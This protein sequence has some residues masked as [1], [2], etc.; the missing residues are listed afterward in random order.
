MVLPPPP[1]A[2]TPPPPVDGGA[3]PPPPPPDAGAPVALGPAQ[4]FVPL[5]TPVTFDRTVTAAQRRITV[6]PPAMPASTVGVV[7]SL[8]FET[9]STETLDL[10][11]EPAGSVMTVGP[12]QSHV[13]CFMV[14]LDAAGAFTI[15][16]PGTATGTLRFALT[17]A[18][19]PEA[20]GGQYVHLLDQP[21]RWLATSPN[22][23]GFREIWTRLSETLRY[24]IVGAAQG[25]TAMLGAVHVGPHVWRDERI[26]LNLGGA[27][28]ASVPV[29]GH[30]P[31]RYSSFFLAPASSSQQL[32]VTASW[33]SGIDDDGLEPWVDAVGYLSPSASLVYRPLPTARVATVQQDNNSPV[34]LSTGL[35]GVSGV[36]GTLTFDLPHW[37]YDERNR[38]F[39]VHVGADESTFPGALGGGL[40]GPDWMTAGLNQNGRVTVRFVSRVTPSGTFV[41]RHH[42][43]VAG[44][45]SEA[46]S[47]HRLTVQVRIEG[48]L[49]PK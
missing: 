42:S 41:M 28:W 40:E 38:W 35:S 26:T 15:D 48:A 14:Q 20:A 43:Y 19:V 10:H 34:Q 9:A 11:L 16:V 22:D 21:V 3:P 2:G 12:L 49:A 44:G 6:A 45:S 4:V 33:A 25:A 47:Y 27:A 31:W 29:D 5:S 32:D 36:F 13:H 37:P 46:A 23:D 8:T 7:G 24:E 1:D 17:A 39:F 18:L 30:F